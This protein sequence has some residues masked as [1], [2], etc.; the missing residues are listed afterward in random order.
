MKQWMVYK[1]EV[2]TAPLTADVLLRSQPTRELVDTHK[3]VIRSDK[4]MTVRVFGQKVPLAPKV[5]LHDVWAAGSGR[6]ESHR[7][8]TSDISSDVAFVEASAS[9]PRSSSIVAGS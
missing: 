2:N 7:R 8:C 1:I 4:R 9:P 5:H 3:D 6:T